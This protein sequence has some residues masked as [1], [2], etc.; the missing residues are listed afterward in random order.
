MLRKRTSLLMLRRKTNVSNLLDQVPKPKRAIP[1]N[2]PPDWYKLPLDSLIPIFDQPSGDL[3]FSRNNIGSEIFVSGGAEFDLSDP[4]C[5]TVS[6]NYQPLHDRNLKKFYMQPRFIRRFKKLNMITNKNEVICTLKQFNEYRRFLKRLYLN[7]VNMVR[8]QLDEIDRDYRNLKFANQM[9]QKCLVIS[10]RR[11][12]VEEKRHRFEEKMK[13]SCTDKEAKYAV[14]KRNYEEAIKRFENIKEFKRR[15]LQ[16]KLNCKEF[17]VTER[18]NC[19][20]KME[21]RRIIMTQRKIK[22][23]TELIKQRQRSIKIKKQINKEKTAYD[24]YERKIEWRRQKTIDDNK[25]LALNENNTTSNVMQRIKKNATA[26]KRELQKTTLKLV[27]LIRSR[28]QQRTIENIVHVLSLEINSKK[29]VKLYNDK[30]EENNNVPYEPRELSDIGL[31]DDQYEYGNLVQSD[32][33]QAVESA[34]NNMRK[35][36]NSTNT[37]NVLIEAI[38]ILNRIS[39][40]FTSDLPRDDAVE[41]FVRQSVFSMFNEVEQAQILRLTSIHLA[42]QVKSQ[43]SSKNLS[44]TKLKQ[45][46]AK[47]RKVSFSEKIIIIVGE[48]TFEGNIPNKRSAK[49]PI[50]A[51]RIEKL[52]RNIFNNANDFQPSIDIPDELN[53]RELQHLYDYQKIM[54]LENLDR[55]KTNLTLKIE[56]NITANCS[57]NNNNQFNN[58]T[59]R[60]V[61]S[62]LTLPE[63]DVNFSDT[64]L[65]ISQILTRRIL[66]DIADSTGYEKSI[67]NDSNI[68]N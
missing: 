6:F 52:C 37:F 40:G 26:Y 47:H 67:N 23:E 31:T 53:K 27:D 44:P 22:T 12:M 16:T 25:L 15:K 14:S 21:K 54:I 19:L 55:L 41:R 28:Y 42:P 10:K 7:Q 57:L 9:T 68:F 3:I 58:C 24:N 17:Q 29:S 60:A 33:Q 64:V 38:H 32:I 49:E 34:F 65:Y 8:D 46:Q 62:I 51:T 61:N 35:I 18:R 20:L 2:G 50:P 36:H 56:Q 48:S 1:L 4:Y 11:Q 13:N 45:S 39:K 63:K 66:K 59:D 43:S 5:Q 30:Q